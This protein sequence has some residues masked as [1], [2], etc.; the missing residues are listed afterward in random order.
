MDPLNAQL[1]RACMAYD[2]AAMRQALTNGAD[3]NAVD[4][5]GRTLLHELVYTVPTQGRQGTF[6]SI[7]C[8]IEH[9]ANP[10][11]RDNAGRTPLMMALGQNDSEKA[12]FLI[13]CGADKHEIEGMAHADRL[14][15]RTSA[16]RAAADSGLGGAFLR[17]IENDDEPTTLAERVRN[18]TLFADL[19]G[20]EDVQ[21]V[22]AAW[23][24]QQ[25]ARAALAD[26]PVSAPHP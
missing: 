12:Q 19:Q 11:V 16:L 5:L 17:A 2:L 22:A 21:R 9:G 3:P 10:S 24:A 18:A 1:R 15:A 23:L 4:D 8:L 25:A 6:K 20:L 7:L 13:A 14:L 26:V